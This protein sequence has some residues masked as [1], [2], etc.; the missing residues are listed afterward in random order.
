M[1][2]MTILGWACGLGAIGWALQSGETIRFFVNLRAFVLVFGGT[3]GATLI[4]YPWSIMKRVP[5]AVLLF[6]FPGRRDSADSVMSLI[7]AVAGRARR[8]SME[9]IEIDLRNMRDQFLA[10]GL[11]MIADGFPADL[12]R[13]NLEK[14]IHFIRLRHSEVANVFR[15]MAT[16]APIFGLLGT[17]VGVVEVLLNLTDPRSM[18]MHMAVAM[19]ATFYGIFGANFLFLPIA[20]KLHSYSEQELFLKEVMIEG[21]L[22][23][24]RQEVPAI[25]TRRLQAYLN[26]DHAPVLPSAQRPKPE[27]AT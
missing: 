13:A 11:K 5:M 25:L 7:L 8:T 4:T 19:T 20:G 23:I 14:E 24:Q 9:S 22:S 2:M 6:I 18:G 16:Y 1:D 17:L 10:N 27:P 21:V 3:L 15:N 26:R 12:I